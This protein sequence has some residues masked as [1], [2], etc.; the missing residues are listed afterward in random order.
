M[1]EDVEVHELVVIDRPGVSS[2]C[3]CGGATDPNLPRFAGDLEWV[4]GQGIRV[5]RIDPARNLQAVREFPSAQAR[6]AVESYSALPLVLVDGRVV[7]GGS[8]PTRDWLRGALDA[9][10]GSTRKG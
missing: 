10:I 3:A 1:S 8:Y 7:R 4:R 5:R 9:A 2:G 6:L